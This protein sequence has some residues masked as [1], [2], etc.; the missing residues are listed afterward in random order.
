[1]RKKEEGRVCDVD[2]RGKGRT[3]RERRR[4]MRKKERRRAT[5]EEERKENSD[6]S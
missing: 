2:Q 5:N 4:R 3:K 6:G 1:M